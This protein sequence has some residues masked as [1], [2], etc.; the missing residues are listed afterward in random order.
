MKLTAQDL[1][2]FGVIDGII[3]EPPCGAHHDP[4]AVYTAIDHMIV[5][6]FNKL[7]KM[8]GSDYAKQRYEKF[9]NIDKAVLRQAGK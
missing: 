9:R 7:K 1:Y 4:D 2:S 8:S 5:S 6:E 3:P